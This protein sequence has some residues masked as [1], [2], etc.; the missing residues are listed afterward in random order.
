[1]LAER[2]ATWPK[3]WEAEGY[4]KGRKQGRKEGRTSGLLE[5][6]RMALTELAKEKFGDLEARFVRLIEEASEDQLR[7]WLKNILKA[8]APEELFRN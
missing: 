1:M 3:Q 6:Q 7:Q 5:G 4:Q 8:T 2:A